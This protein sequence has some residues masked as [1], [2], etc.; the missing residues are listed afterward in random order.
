MGYFVCMHI[1]NTCADR[2]RCESESFSTKWS[3]GRERN[4]EICSCQGSA[5]LRL[6]PEIFWKNHTFE[7]LALCCLRI[8]SSDQWNQKER[9]R[10]RV[11]ERE[12]E[13]ERE[14]EK[15]KEREREMR[16]RREGRMELGGVIKKQ[17]WRILMYGQARG[18]FFGRQDKSWF[19][20]CVWSR[21]ISPC[22]C[23]VHLF[24]YKNIYSS[25]EKETLSLIKLYFSA[26]G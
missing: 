23:H 3:A 5:R 6:L 20:V 12:W 19:L 14:R 9:E 8:S 15:E 11:W 4:K 2:Q 26:S 17:S 1:I 25:I 24:V 7:G 10:E 22:S 13:R 18:W 16:G 21:F